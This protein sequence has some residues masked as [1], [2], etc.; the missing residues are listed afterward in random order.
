MSV[1]GNTIPAFAPTFSDTGGTRDI[2]DISS[3]DFLQILVTELLNQ[4]PLDPMSNKELLEQI[5]AIR[6]LESMSSLTS[7]NEG[8]VFSSNLSSASSL[9]GK[10]VEGE[11]TDGSHIVGLVESVIVDDKQVLL[12]TGQGYI[13]VEN[14][15]GITD[16]NPPESTEG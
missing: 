10:I 16:Y 9:I 15:R 8:L 13:P 3:M 14:I 6:N 11:N 1:I 7:S 5:S 12:V 4:D 2:N